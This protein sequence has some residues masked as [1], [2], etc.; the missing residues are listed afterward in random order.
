MPEEQISFSAMYAIAE[1]SFTGTQRPDMEFTN[2]SLIDNALVV[3]GILPGGA[4]IVSN[5]KIVVD[6]PQRE[7]R[8]DNICIGVSF[9]LSEYVVAGILPGVWRIR[10]SRGQRGQEGQS[11]STPLTNDEMILYSLIFG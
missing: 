1:E 10:F 3:S 5:E 4:V 8:Q 11:L 7:V 9:D 6:V 2:A